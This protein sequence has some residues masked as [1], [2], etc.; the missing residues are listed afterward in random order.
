MKSNFE[1]EEI[2]QRRAK[3]N[4]ILF[5]VQTL[6]REM[7]YKTKTGGKKQKPKRKLVNKMY[8]S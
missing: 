8:T 7:R 6:Q 1:A 2:K 5:E 3:G 4:S